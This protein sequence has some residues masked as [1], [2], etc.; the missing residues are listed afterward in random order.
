MHVIVYIQ[1]PELSPFKFIENRTVLDVSCG[2]NFVVVVLKKNVATRRTL[3]TKN[4]F[5]IVHKS[6]SELAAFDSEEFSKGQTLLL[7]F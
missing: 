1:V 7:E 5:V 2:A 3:T 6:D 4:S